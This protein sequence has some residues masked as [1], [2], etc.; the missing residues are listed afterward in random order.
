[1]PG[2]EVISKY[3]FLKTKK[4]KGKDREIVKQ[5]GDALD[6][7]YRDFGK[8]Y[9][10]FENLDSFKAGLE[11]VSGLLWENYRTITNQR[12]QRLYTPVPPPPPGNLFTR[13]LGMLAHQY[14]F[15]FQQGL[16]AETDFNTAP[17]G[18]TLIAGDPFIGSLIRAKL[19]WKDAI[20]ADHGEHSHSL[21]WLVAA[22]LLNGQTT[23]SIPDLYARTVDYWIMSRGVDTINLW[24]LLVDSFPATGTTARDP[25][26]RL[27]TDSWRCPQNVTRYLLGNRNGF[28]P[29]AGHFVSNYLY[30]RYSNRNWISITTNKETNTSK[31]N[32]ANIYTDTAAKAKEGWKQGEVNPARLTRKTVTPGD[33]GDRGVTKVEFHSAPGLLYMKEG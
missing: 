22:Q 1:M 13:C 5:D 9:D 6:A 2:Y 8:I 20:S 10:L 30:K 25:D 29:I 11:T 19:F 16:S 28:Q 3:R 32:L 12:N 27:L 26:K 4:E 18:T 23:S 7:D 21:Q 33:I 14:G 15:T 17:I 24:Q 31:M